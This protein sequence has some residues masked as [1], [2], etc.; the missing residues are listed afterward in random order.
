M[1]LPLGF[2]RAWVGLSSI[3]VLGLGVA[4][5]VF[6][7]LYVQLFIYHKKSFNFIIYFTIIR[8]VI[9]SKILWILVKIST[10]LR[11]NSLNTDL[12]YLDH[13]FLS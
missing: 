5:I 9:I 2:L 8:A 11:S 13:C 10:P 6:D 1:C 4:M 3:I 12:L 7:V